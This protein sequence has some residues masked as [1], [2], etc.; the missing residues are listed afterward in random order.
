MS[1][2]SL[3]SIHRVQK[4]RITETAGATLAA[5]MTDVPVGDPLPCRVKQLSASETEENMSRSVAAK[6]RVFFYFDPEIP[7]SRSALIYVD[8]AGVS[9]RL[10]VRTV[11]EPH[12]MGYFWKVDC[13]E[14]RD[15][16][17]A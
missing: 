10:L 5:V 9:H 7:E 1:R 12:G 3:M 15:L 6:W 17:E 11:T 8:R 14:N 13:D 2:E 16:P 4:V